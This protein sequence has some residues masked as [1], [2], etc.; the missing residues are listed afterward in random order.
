MALN[1]YVDH[2]PKLLNGGPKPTKW[3]GDSAPNS[4]KIDLVLHYHANE[5][6]QKRWG[7]ASLALLDKACRTPFPSRFVV[8]RGLQ[9]DPKLV[10]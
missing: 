5:L 9:S 7:I 2:N 10:A 4:F 6:P 3:S 1:Q 8:E